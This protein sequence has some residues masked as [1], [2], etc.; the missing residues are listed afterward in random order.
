MSTLKSVIITLP[1]KGMTSSKTNT[2]SIVTGDMAK[3]V[4]KFNFTTSILMDKIK[5]ENSIKKVPSVKHMEFSVPVPLAAD[6]IVFK[7]ENVALR[8]KKRRLDHLT[9][10]EKLQRK[11]LKNRVAAQT[12][13]DRKKAKLDEL[14]ETVKLLRERNEILIKECTMLRAQ[15]ELL[16]SETKRLK[17]DKEFLNTRE[18]KEQVCSKCQASVDCTVPELGSAVSPIN[19]LQQGGTVQTAQPVTLKPSTT[20]LLKILTLYLLSKIYLA[21]SKQTITSN[22][23]KNLPKAFCERLPLKWKQILLHQM[24]KIQLKKKVPTKN[25]IIQKRWWGRHQVMWKPIHLVET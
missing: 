1:N 6:N 20:I 11:K 3:S 14:E 17:E 4:S 7:Q 16:I 13:R 5:L 19:P 25:L 18:S 21:N 24:N 9:W 15:N 12:S 2:S 8:G 10:E 22:D 23:L